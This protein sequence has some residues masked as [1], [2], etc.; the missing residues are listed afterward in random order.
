MDDVRGSNNFDRIALTRQMKDATLPN[1]KRMYRAGCNSCHRRCLPSVAFVI[2]AWLQAAC[3]GSYLQE[4]STTRLSKGYRNQLLLAGGNNNRGFDFSSTL[5]WETFYQQEAQQQSDKITEWHSSVP[6]SVIADRVPKLAKR[7]ILVGCGN[8]ELPAVLR[9]ARPACHL[10][11]LDSSPTCISILE[12][13]YKDMPNAEFLCGDAVNMAALQGEG[14]SQ[15]GGEKFEAVVD[16]GLIDAF[17]CGDDWNTT[18]VPL[19][20]Q[21]SAIL[22]EEDGVYV[23]VSYKLAPST[24]KFLREVGERVGLAWEFDVDGS[25]NRVGISIAKRTQG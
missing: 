24:Q 5:K 20:E 10:V 4:L 8:S 16:K 15:M 12:E 6:L 9:K 13:R 21:A 22:Q 17:F 2:A 25:N 3:R 18:I 23:L 14:A 7:C 11:M 19:L 1:K